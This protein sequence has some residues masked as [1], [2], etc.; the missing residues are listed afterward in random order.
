[1][2]SFTIDK[3][4]CISCQLC[5][6]NCVARIIAMSDGYP[7]IP[8]EREA[9]CY[10]CQHCLAV[11]PTGALSIL[12][13][14][15]SDSRPLAGNCPSPE[16]LETLIKGRRSIRNYKQENLEPEIINRLLEV[17]WHAPT[18]KNCR[19]V[20]FTV[21][22]DLDRMNL[23]KN[24]IMLALGRL[25]REDGIPEGLS[26]FNDFVKLWEDKG[27]DIIFRDAPHLLIASAP[28]NCA[29]PEQDCVIALSYFELFAQS[30]GVGTVWDGFAHYIFNH[31]LPE[32]RKTLNIPDDHVIGY[33]MAF[34]KPAVNYARTAQHKPALINRV[35]I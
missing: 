27:I 17:A 29:T 32:F 25:S 8:E 13:L 24:Q 5:A 31:L 34:G 14:K 22:D 10:K 4:T 19:Q 11:C 18:G 30:M 16:Q 2:L 12:G 7:L 3:S 35:S 20:L 6:K 33:A 28:A 21:V 23:L 15:A 9:G 1:M 26:F